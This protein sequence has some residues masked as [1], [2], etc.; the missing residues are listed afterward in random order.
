MLGAQRAEIISG[1]S[2][3]TGVARQA[4]LAMEANRESRSIHSYIW[5]QM[6]P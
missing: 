5:W 4:G 3:R 1:T 2:D 6:R